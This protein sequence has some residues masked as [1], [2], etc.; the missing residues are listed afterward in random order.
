MSKKMP[1]QVE[2]RG[3]RSPLLLRKELSKELSFMSR[4]SS[5]PSLLPNTFNYKNST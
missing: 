3:E 2:Q 1:Q 5:T 4:G